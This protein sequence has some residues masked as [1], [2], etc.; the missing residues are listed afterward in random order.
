MI[1][2]LKKKRVLW[3]CVGNHSQGNL[4][5]FGYK[6]TMKMEIY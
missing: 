2:F 5:M 6:P 4:V 3:C 1:E